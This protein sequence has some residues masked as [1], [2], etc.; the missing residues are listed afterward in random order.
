[1]TLQHILT[2]RRPNLPDAQFD[3]LQKCFEQVFP[4][5]ER[6]QIPEATSKTVEGWDSIAQ[7]TLLSL[8]G[9][10]FNLDVDFEAF[11]GATSFA[12]VRELVRQKTADASRV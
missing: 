5:L 3:R 6:S 10:E 11:E 1:M 2:V 8:I 7:L 9:E 4:K 12:S